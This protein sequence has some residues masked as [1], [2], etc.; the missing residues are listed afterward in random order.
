MSGIDKKQL[1]HDPVAE[2][3]VHRIAQ[4]N[5]YR[6]Q[7]L[8]G[9]LVVLVVVTG[10]SYYYREQTSVPEEASYLLANAQSPA[11]LERVASE[12]PGTYAAASALMT[13]GRTLAQQTNYAGA[14]GYYEQVINDIPDSPLKPVAVR[15]LAKCYVAQEDYDRAVDLLNREIL[16][17]KSS[18]VTVLA[19]LDLVHALCAAER[20]EEAWAALQEWD[21]LVGQ[22]YI[23]TV[24]DGLREEILRVTGI[25]TNQMAQQNYDAPVL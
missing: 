10:I 25:S 9:V 12:Y 24:A 6:K 18:Y 11:D 1:K 2:W 4:L 22:S 20:Y 3:I 15:A 23:S 17:D 21:S 5:P 7:I 8:A 19:Q 13:M 16:Y 14:A